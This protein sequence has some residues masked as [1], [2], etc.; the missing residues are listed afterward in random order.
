MGL[1]PTPVSYTHLQTTEGLIDFTGASIAPISKKWDKAAGVWSDY[2]APLITAAT[3]AAKITSLT[4]PEQ[5]AAVLTLPTVAEGYTVSIKSS[6]N[7]GIIALDGTITAPDET[8]E[9]KLVL[10]VSDG[11]GDTADTEM[12]IRDRY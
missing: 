4:N 10:T 3:E 1:S 8:T 6:S 5:G 11:A 7:T 9:V 2:T 12:C